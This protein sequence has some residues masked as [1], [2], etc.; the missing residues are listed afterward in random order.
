MAGICGFLW[1]FYLC[2]TF[3][4]YGFSTTSEA[5]IWL[6]CG[7]SGRWWKFPLESWCFSHM[8]MHLQLHWNMGKYKHNLVRSYGRENLQLPNSFLHTQEYSYGHVWD[9]SYWCCSVAWYLDFLCFF[10]FGCC[11]WQGVPGAYSEAAAAK[12]YPQCEA[13]PCEQ[14]DAAFQVG[15]CRFIHMT[16]VVVSPSIHNSWI[17]VHTLCTPPLKLPKKHV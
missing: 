12:A 2:R 7:I 14:F 1:Y 13:V 3:V 17:S 16:W 8:T 9:A 10:N 11:I 4:N 15:C 6:A 5:W